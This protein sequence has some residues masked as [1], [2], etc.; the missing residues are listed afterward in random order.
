MLVNHSLRTERP[1]GSNDIG[2]LAW[3][4]SMKTP[5]YPQGRDLILISNDVTF[6]AGSFGV[7]EDPTQ[8][9]E[10]LRY[11][12]TVFAYFILIL[13]FPEMAWGYLSIIH[14]SL[15]FSIINQP[16]WV[17]PFMEPPHIPIVASHSPNTSCGFHS[18]FPVVIWHTVLAQ[19][20]LLF[21]VCCLL[22]ETLRISYTLHTHGWLFPHVDRFLCPPMFGFQSWLEGNLQDT[23]ICR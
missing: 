21:V 3:K 23:H 19:N 13:W 20:V 8:Q 15:G 18:P 14:F 4:M 7:K 1:E 9:V 5:E 22:P 16:F 10:V 2:M 17:Y 6:Q 11:S 12:A